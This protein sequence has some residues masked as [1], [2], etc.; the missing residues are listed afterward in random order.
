VR[1]PWRDVWE[2]LIGAVSRVLVLQG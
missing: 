1:L 2:S